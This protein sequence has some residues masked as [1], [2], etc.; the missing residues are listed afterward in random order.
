MVKLKESRE[1]RMRD[2]QLWVTVACFHLILISRFNTLREILWF[3]VSLVIILAISYFSRD[4]YSCHYQSKMRNLLNID[5]PKDPPK[6][7]TLFI[8]V[9]KASQF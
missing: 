2:E 8:K 1:Q 7:V 9:T 5:I 6:N 4:S 3:I